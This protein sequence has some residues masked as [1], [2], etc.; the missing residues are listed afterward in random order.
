[1]ETSERKIWCFSLLIYNKANDKQRKCAKALSSLQENEKTQQNETVEIEL[2]CVN[3]KVESWLMFLHVEISL[4]QAP[5][6]KSN[7]FNCL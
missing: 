5:N 2:P 4:K 7:R 3:H 6:G 1:M